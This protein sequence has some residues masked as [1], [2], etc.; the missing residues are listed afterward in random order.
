MSSGNNALTLEDGDGMLVHH[1]IFDGGG[2]AS[3]V[4]VWGAGTFK[5]ARFHNNLFLR[6]DP[7]SEWALAV[8]FGRD[9]NMAWALRMIVSNAAAKLKK[10]AILQILE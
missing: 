10:R 4:G 7:N 6:T 3:P 5:N 2:Y 8:Y 9:G 1:N